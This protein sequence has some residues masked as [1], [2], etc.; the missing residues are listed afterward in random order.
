MASVRPSVFDILAVIRFV[1]GLVWR[2]EVVAPML[3]IFNFPSRLIST[4][5]AK[6][7]KVDDP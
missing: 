2:A 4:N 3:P 1:P 5:E 6:W 7:L